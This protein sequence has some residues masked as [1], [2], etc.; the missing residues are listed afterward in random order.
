MFLATAK[1]R[2]LILVCEALGLRFRETKT[3]LIFE[4][5]ANGGYRKVV[6]HLHSE[7]RDIATG[8]FHS[9]VKDLGFDSEEAFRRFLKTI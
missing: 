6:I 1:Y 2:D 9:Y 8:T 5:M 4:G 3:C 7:G